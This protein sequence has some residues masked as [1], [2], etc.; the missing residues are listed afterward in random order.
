M[1]K[2]N[3]NC[4][5][6]EGF[7]AYSIGLDNEI[8]PLISSANIACGYH[9]GDPCVMRRTVELCKN[10]SVSI[11]AHPGFPDLMGFGRRNINASAREVEDY[12][13]YQIGALDAFCR[14]CGTKLTH[15]KPHGALYNTAAKDEKLAKAIVSAVY[16]FDK[17]I[18]LLA[19]SGSKMIEQAE[20][21][22]LKAA[23]E[24]FADRAYEN[25]GSLVSRNKPGAMITNEAEAVSRIIKMIT[26]GRAEAIDS[27]EINIQA[28][29]VCVHGDGTK[30]LEFVQ[31]LN[32]AFKEKN[33]EV[34]P[35]P[36][37]FD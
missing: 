1:F 5:L 25:D 15:V 17:S 12:V 36:G 30:A 10:N 18:I 32:N 19:L 4:D 31:K 33:I 29:S 6:G 21:A 16:N 35:I 27:S 7:G 14:S 11:G 23:R 24:V 2:V 22:G 20:L 28:D 34:V 26:E 8:I 3:L 9:A 13:I 37:L